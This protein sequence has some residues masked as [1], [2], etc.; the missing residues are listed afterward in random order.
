MGQLEV[1][2]V[3]GAPPAAWAH[4][5][6]VFGAGLLDPLPL[7]THELPLDQFP[8]AIELVG[9]GGPKVGKVLLLP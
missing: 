1:R 2:T 4:A 3:F 5:V 8:D 9:S 7:V 6:R